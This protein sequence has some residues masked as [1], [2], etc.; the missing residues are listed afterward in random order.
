LG[1]LVST[2]ISS[3]RLRINEVSTKF[4][5][6]ADLIS[7]CNEAQK[8]VVRETKCLE[9]T[10]TS[11]SDSGIQNYALPLDFMALRRLLYNGKGVTKTDFIE[12]DEAC[13]D[14]SNLGGTPKSYYLWNDSIN[15]IPIP[16]VTGDPIKIF[17]YKTPIAIT[18]STQTLEVNTLY[19]DLLV[20]Y[21]AYLALVKD[22]EEPRADYQMQECNAKLAQVK[23]HLKEKDLSRP[24][25]FKFSRNLSGRGFYRR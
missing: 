16:N 21:M 12:I 23:K 7:Y 13:I 19:D 9:E 22:G 20:A 10:S 17:Y 25:R 3:G 24:P 5:T 2:I 4:H 15:F 14:E 8:Y 6:N 11:T 18:L 1:S